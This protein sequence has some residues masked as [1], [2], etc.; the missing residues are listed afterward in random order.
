MG[1]NLSNV[2]IDYQS[3]GAMLDCMNFLGEKAVNSAEVERHSDI[4]KAAT[5]KVM[6]EKLKLIADKLAD[7]FDRNVIVHCYNQ[8]REHQPDLM[9]KVE[10]E[11]LKDWKDDYTL[12]MSNVIA[13]EKQARARQDAFDKFLETGDLPEMEAGMRNQPGRETGS[14]NPGKSASVDGFDEFDVKPAKYTGR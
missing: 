4:R 5:L 12:R 13:A 3:R 8:F 2:T 1:E 11:N 10:S 6:G 9:H 7:G 14:V